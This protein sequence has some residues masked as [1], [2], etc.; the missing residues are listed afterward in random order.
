MEGEPGPVG[1]ESVS[2]PGSFREFPLLGATLD[3][4][5]Q[6]SIWLSQAL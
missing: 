6:L 1:Q 5:T 4:F 3:F 2:A